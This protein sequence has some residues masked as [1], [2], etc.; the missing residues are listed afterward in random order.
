MFC[1]FIE[2]I[3]VEWTFLKRRYTGG[4]KVCEKMFSISKSLL[5]CKSEHN[6]VLLQIH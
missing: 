2:N 4:Q 3:K 1:F 6:E 5:K